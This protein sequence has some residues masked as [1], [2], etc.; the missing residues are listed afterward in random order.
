[1]QLPPTASSVNIPRAP[2]VAVSTA[3]IAGA[4]SR[5]PPLAAP[6][7]VPAP[8]PLTVGLPDP[9][10]VQQQK[11][12]FIK[13]LDDQLK[14]GASSLDKQVREQR[15]Q[16]RSQA[17]QQKAIFAMQVDQEVRIQ[18]MKVEHRFAIQVKE[19]KQQAMRQRAALEQQAL[20]LSLEYQGR[21]AE[22][23]MQ[24]QH[25]SLHQEHQ[26]IQ[27]KIRS[28]PNVYVPLP[29][30]PALA[31]ATH[32]LP[33]HGQGVVSAVGTPSVSYV[34]QPLAPAPVSGN[35]TPTAPMPSSNYV[36]QMPTVTV[37]SGGYSS[38]GMPPTAYTQ[39]PTVISQ[40]P[41]SSVLPASAPLSS[42]VMTTHVAA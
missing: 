3:S 16:V 1:M 4:T 25:Y 17:E 20:Q 33:N 22:E 24:T 13:S 28:L 18:E 40:M 9:R 2:S 27:D 11:E 23:D 41:T 10:S 5:G 35:V 38:Y 31:P 6:P 14:A 36:M 21:R 8:Q 12:S 29:T 42:R 26:T 7:H 34:P 30:A 19:L 39:P 32:L 37:A 15:E